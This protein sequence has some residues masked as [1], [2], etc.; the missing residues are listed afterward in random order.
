MDRNEGNA[1]LLERREGRRESTSGL[2]EWM[3]ETGEDL[4]EVYAEPPDSSRVQSAPRATQLR[5]RQ[6][7]VVGQL[8]PRPCGYSPAT[9]LHIRSQAAI[10]PFAAARPHFRLAL[11]SSARG[12]HIHSVQP[13]TPLR[14]L[15]PSAA[16]APACHNMCLPASLRRGRRTAPQLPLRSSGWPSRPPRVGAA[17]SG[18][19][20]RAGTFPSGGATTRPPFTGVTCSNE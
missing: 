14:H 20:V 17:P 9:S 6:G 4:P 2:E 3:S 8:S 16:P 12:T 11:R 7:W 19:A 18:V 1:C 10:V 13:R 15:T 5:E